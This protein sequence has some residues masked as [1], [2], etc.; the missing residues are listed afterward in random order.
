MTDTRQRTTWG[1]R[2][3]FLVR[4]FG[5]TGLFATVIGA[6]LFAS[7]FPSPSQWT[8]QTVQAAG[9]GTHGPFAKVAAWTLAAGVVSVAIALVV[10][11]LSGLLLITGRRT[12]ASVSATVGTLAAL[13]LLVFVNA[14]SFTHHRRLDFTRDHQFTL[15]PELAE[16]LRSLR[17][18][19]P[20]TIV[21]HQMHQTFGS[22]T[23]ERDSYTSGAE[24]KVTEKVK[25]VVDLFRELGPRFNIEVL[26]TEA[27]E[28]NRQLDAITKDAPALRQAIESSPE[29]SI[30]FFANDRVQRLAFN[31]FLQLDKTASKEANSGRGNLVLLP[32]GVENFARRV[33]AVQE[34]RPKVA[35]LVVHELLTTAYP[36]GRGR[37]FTMAGLKKALTTHGFDVTDVVLKK[38]W[39]SAGSLEELKPAAD[40]REES[41]LE[42]LE[43]ALATAADETAA[44]R[45]QAE[46]FGQI[47]TRVEELKGRPWAERS[48]LYAR[49]VRGGTVTEELE[50]EVLASLQR[51]F[52][53]ADQ[54]L[55]DARKAQ[56]SAEA[57]L[58]D[59]LSDERTIEGR[60]I[61]DVKAK[62][63]RVLA[64]VDLIVIPR[65]TV[66]DAT[67]GPDVAASLHGI[68]K[69]QADVI[70]DFMLK[71]KPVLAL[72][73][74]ISSRTG[75]ATD[76]PDPLEK[77]ITERGI[78]LGNETI[79]FDGEAAAFASRRAG[80]QFGG[81][82]P[83]DIPPLVLVETPDG[84]TDIKPNPVAA[85]ARLTARSVDQKLDLRARALRPVYV[86]PW[87]SAEPRFAAEFVQT[88]PDAWN[89]VRP[90][91]Q[92]RPL[93]DGT[94]GVTDIPRF[95]PTPLDDPRKGTL[96]EERRGPFPIGVA[97][98][99]P[100]PAHWSDDRLAPTRI[101]A[102]LV[103]GPQFQKLIAG[104]LASAQSNRPKG[105]SS[106]LIVFGSGNLFSGPKLEPAQEKLLLHS[107]NWL[108][109]RE[110]RMPQASQA[111]WQF[112]RVEMTEREFSLWRYGTAIG[113][114]LVAVYLGLMVTM[115]RRLR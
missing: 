73:G 112:P 53:R 1:T 79:L 58:R 77:L 39:A 91:P 57:K 23:D 12:A 72:L 82:V 102:M 38:N 7:E 95:E 75:P 88:G 21:V 29:N 76:G 61:T 80:E 70:R 24:R 36:E 103:A 13:A 94:F 59:A 47:R 87:V 81:G 16:K 17:P 3:R 101:A 63:T 40:T 10:E 85:A 20:T 90:F 104:A 45:E 37:A 113:L 43:G 46:I 78:V 51:Q 42:R 9:E 98:D 6:G 28:Y 32:Q 18:E 50:P 83:T 66:E 22:L 35:V 8:T 69:E 4:A 99:G 5:L 114:P 19:S 60:R 106:R 109:G 31:E 107:A 68:S 108:T 71:G 14:Y 55:I 64:D 100:S 86:A 30:F 115:F 33:L 67:E 41:T 26:D 93:P 89:E 97:I 105:T 49:L 15:A 74:P 52:N 65:F 11:L 44:A 27:F 110:D 111:A 34:R 84:K 2:F 92:V 56:A 25:D 96:E 62:L 54:I 48:A